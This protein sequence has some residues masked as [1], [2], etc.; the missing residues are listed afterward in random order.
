MTEAL[1]DALRAAIGA[2]H[3]LSDV[4]VLA[5]YET[6]WTRRFHGS[7][8]CVARPGST[9]EVSDVLRACAAAGAAVVPQGGNTGLVGGGVPRGGEVVLSTRRLDAIEHVDTEHGDLVAGAGVP[10]A[11]ARDVAH[12]AGWDVAVDLASRDS[13]TIGGMVATNAGGEHVIRYGA[14]ERQLVGVEAVLGDGTVVGRVPAL[15]KDNTGYRWAG[16]LAGSEGTLAVVTRVH[17]AL[18]PRLEARVVALVA[19]DGIDAALAVASAARRDLDSVLA[20]ELLL[21]DGVALVCDHRGLHRPFS[22]E[23][24]A[25][26]LVECGARDDGAG[27]AA[28]IAR[29]LAG[30]DE[31]RDSAVAEDA[32]ARERLWAYREGH[33]EAINAAG[34]P[35]K[36]DVTLPFDALARFVAEARAVV[37]SIDPGARVVVFGHVGDGNLHVN[38]LGPAPDD[39]RTDHEVLALAARMGGSISAEHGIG[40]AKRAE[41]ALMRSA[42]EL[43]AM[44]AIKQALDPAGILNPGVLL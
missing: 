24:P 33:T 42:A 40:V 23:W 29:V 26:L 5:T 1:V 38:V 22:E 44:R 27:C 8:R 39:D 18:V 16:I 13:A 19:V 7:A 30:R 34:V 32:S 31:V 35:H 43:D 37:S 6:D 10:L 2:E 41:L 14:T 4:D 9:R 3:V 15:R 21:A 17:L 12:A 11:R 36:L 28:E 25:Y 20:L